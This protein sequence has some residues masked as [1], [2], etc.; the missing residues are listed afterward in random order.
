MLAFFS[1]SLQRP[2]RFSISFSL[3]ATESVVCEALDDCL[4]RRPADSGLA[5]VEEVSK[6]PARRC[7]R[8]L[9]TEIAF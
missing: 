3:P 1:R 2:V 7:K 4:P 6:P 9:Q 8:D 5:E